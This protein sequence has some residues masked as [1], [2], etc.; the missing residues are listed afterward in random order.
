MTSSFNPPSSTGKP[1]VPTW[2]PPPATTADVDFAQLRT[3]DLALLDSPDPREVQEL[4]AT[5]KSAIREDGFLFLVNY[6]VSFE[7]AS[8]A[9][10]Q[11]PD[12]QLMRQFS[13]AQYMFDNISQE[14]KERLLWDPKSG[15]FPGYKPD[16]GWSVSRRI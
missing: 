16:H 9:K 5:A 1:H 10:T 3:V 4:V 13:L 14:D 2:V 6:G 7:Q 12:L 8:E 11:E 15:M